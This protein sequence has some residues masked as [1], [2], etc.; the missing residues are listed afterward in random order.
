MDRAPDFA[1]GLTWIFTAGAP[2][3]VIM[4]RFLHLLKLGEFDW[5]IVPMHGL[6]LQPGSGEVTVAP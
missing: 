2:N 5:V 4:Y 3:Q 1:D 6:P